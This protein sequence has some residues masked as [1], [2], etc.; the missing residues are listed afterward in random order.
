MKQAMIH[1]IK[2]VLPEDRKSRI[3]CV[4]FGIPILALWVVLVIRIVEVIVC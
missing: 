3:P 4:V 1:F 2:R